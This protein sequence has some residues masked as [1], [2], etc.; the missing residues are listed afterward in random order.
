MTE[1]GH[2]DLDNHSVICRAGVNQ[3]FLL[4]ETAAEIWR[5]FLKWQD[6]GTVVRELVSIYAADRSMLQQDVARL[7]DEWREGGLIG[8]I[9]SSSSEANPFPLTELTPANVEKG[10]QTRVYAYGECRFSV[11]VKADEC[12]DEEIQYLWHLFSHLQAD[13]DGIHVAFR[14]LRRDGR[15]ILERNGKVLS[16]QNN[17]PVVQ[18]LMVEVI[19]LGHLCSPWMAVLHA[20]AVTRGEGCLVF[21]G[22]SGS[23][24]STLVASLMLAGWEFLADDVCVVAPSG[25]LQPCPAPLSLKSGSW[26]LLDNQWPDLLDAPVWNVGEKVVRYVPPVRPDPCLY[27]RMY[28]V[29]ALISPAYERGKVGSLEPMNKAEMLAAIIHA[30]SLICRPVTPE[31]VSALVEWIRELP[32][33]RLKYGQL[34]DAEKLIGEAFPQ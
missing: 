2:Y 27:G 14:I 22:V 9:T 19:D 15:L 23:G 29:T 33:Y 25:Q 21:P 34:S 6:Q 18:L 16:A 5:L 12:E 10:V 28:S 31:H 32:C 7:V 13:V 17:V 4:N 24:K 20:G 30:E 26:P 8:E 1:Y 11:S 3:I